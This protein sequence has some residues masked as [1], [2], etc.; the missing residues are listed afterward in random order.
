MLGDLRKPLF[1]IAIGLLGLVLLAELGVAVAAP[2]LGGTGGAAGWGIP[3]LALL[4]IQLLF[5]A[6]LMAAPL[7]FPESMTGR[8]Q[9]VA[10]LIVALILIVVGT[11]AG[12]AAFGLLMLLVALLTSAPFGPVAYAAM[13]YSTFPTG[14]A[15]ATLA[16]IMV[17]KL[18]FM[19][20]LALAHQRFL[21][22]KGFMFLIGTSL[23][24][25]IVIS[26]LHGFVPVF[27][28]SVSD[29]IGAIVV[30]I[31]ALIWAVLGLIFGA[32]ATFKAL[33]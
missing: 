3:M 31:L 22:N 8:I 14:S 10:T 15:A 32:I 1:F 23:L 6:L 24:A 21:Q 13:G 7:V 33:A 5:T 30:V 18:G 27:L 4:D 25:T 26:F 9:G 16:F 17:C 2:F 20:V 11:I 28:V 19:G 12:V 29:L